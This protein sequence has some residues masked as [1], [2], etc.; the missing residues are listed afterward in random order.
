MQEVETP[1]E[2][3]FRIS[4]GLYTKFFDAISEVRAR[5]E[6]TELKRKVEEFLGGDIPDV[7]RSGPKVVL[8]RYVAS[9]N[10]EFRYFCDIAK[11]SGLGSVYFEYT[12]DKFVAKNPSK[13]YLCRLYSSNGSGRV[14]KIVDFNKNEGKRFREITT[15]GGK[16]LVDFHHG[17]LD[18]VMAKSNFQK[19]IVH[20]FSQWFLNH[21]NKD[22]LYYLHYLALFVCHGVLFENFLHDNKESDFT[23]NTVVP[24]FKKI[25]EIFGVKPLIFPLQPLKSEEEKNWYEYK[26][27][28]LER[29]SKDMLI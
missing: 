6:D 22:G 2:D 19:P 1:V 24:A 13:Y 3:I 17:L 26:E 20:D 4:E 12:E 21:R 9:P 18:I 28:L 8:V 29:V 10:I 16:N 14:L 25:E 7:L 23:I 15:I 11:L 5:W 27:S